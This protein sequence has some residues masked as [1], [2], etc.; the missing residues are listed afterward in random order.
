MVVVPELR[1]AVTTPLRLP[2]V[3]TPGKLLDHTPP[4]VASVR[5]LVPDA[6]DEIVPLMGAG[7]T[8]T[9]KAVVVKQPV[10]K[11]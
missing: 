4:D 7:A 11:V 1:P 9:T 2:T 3:A 6:H 5:V 10:G 8:F